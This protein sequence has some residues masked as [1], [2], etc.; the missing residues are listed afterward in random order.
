MRLMRPSQSEL[1]AAFTAKSR[2]KLTLVDFTLTPFF[3]TSLTFP[4]PSEEMQS[5]NS[6]LPVGPAKGAVTP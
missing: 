4:Q 6:S 3:T 2:Q 1:H 5:R